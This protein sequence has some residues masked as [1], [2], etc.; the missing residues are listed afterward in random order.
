MVGEG[1]GGYPAAIVIALPFETQ[2][3]PLLIS[4]SHVQDTPHFIM[5]LPFPLHNPFG[6]IDGMGSCS[7]ESGTRNHS[8]AEVLLRSVLVG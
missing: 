8:L 1:A 5:N 6:P 2:Q 3:P 7:F 4:Y